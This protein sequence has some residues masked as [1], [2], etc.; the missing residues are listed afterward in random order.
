MDERS[1][2]VGTGDASNS[3]GARDFMGQPHFLRQTRAFTGGSS[4]RDSNSRVCVSA[5]SGL[6]LG[7]L[8]TKKCMRLQRELG[9]HFKFKK[10]QSKNT[11]VRV[12][13]WK[14]RSKN[15]FE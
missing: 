7:K 4:G 1:S 12:A 14:R 3:S 11:E 15:I 9:L 6:D 5:G 10:I 8:S 2:K 13:L